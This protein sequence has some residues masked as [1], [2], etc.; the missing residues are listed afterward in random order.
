MCITDSFCYK[1]ETN[2][3]LQSNNTPIK[4]FK[5]KEMSCTSPMA[6][7]GKMFPGTICGPYDGVVPGVI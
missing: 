5:K 1:A 3:P 7:Q 4:K 6:D 2:T